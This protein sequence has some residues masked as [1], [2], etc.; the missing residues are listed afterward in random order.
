MPEN[1]PPQS[2]ALRPVGDAIPWNA[3]PRNATLLSGCADGA[4]GD[5]A[6]REIG[7]PA[8]ANR[9]IGEPTGA[10]REIGVPEPANR[11]IGVPE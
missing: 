10:N 5:E 9:E 7:E 4:G 11:E 1:N 8:G 6:N 3:A 2:N